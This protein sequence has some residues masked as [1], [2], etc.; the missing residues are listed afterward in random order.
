[1]DFQIFIVAYH[2]LSIA[3]PFEATAIPREHL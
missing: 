2:A 1:M 3:G